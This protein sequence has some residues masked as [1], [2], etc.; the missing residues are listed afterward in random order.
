MRSQMRGICG[1]KFGF[2]VEKIG[3]EYF[4]ISGIGLFERQLHVPAASFACY[5]LRQVFFNLSPNIGHM[6]NL[7]FWRAVKPSRTQDSSCPAVPG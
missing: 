6:N 5:C 2:G 7:A 4:G 3:M 1:S